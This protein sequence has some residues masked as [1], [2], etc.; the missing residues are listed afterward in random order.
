M[1]VIALI[2]VNYNGGDHLQRCLE[3]VHRQIRPPDRCLLVDNDSRVSP[4]HGDEP[5]LEGVELI[6]TGRN[7]GFAAA[8]NLAA[9]ACPEATWIALLNP[10]TVP[11][12]DW[13]QQLERVAEAHPEFTSFASQLISM[14]PPERLDGAGDGLTLAGRPYRRGFGRPTA[15]QREAR[16]VFSPC[17]AAAFFRQDRFIA[18]GGLDEAFFCYLEDVDLGFRLQLLGDRCLYTPN[19]RVRHAGS[20]LTGYRS[21]FST[22][23]G[24][25][26]MV[27][28]F[29]KN[30]PG[31]LFW[32][33]LPLHLIVSLAAMVR[34]G[35]RGQLQVFA[36]AKLHAWRGLPRMWQERRSIQAQ[37][38]QSTWAIARIL[39]RR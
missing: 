27:W 8:N 18:A 36:K 16:E 26:N 37:R 12:S 14:E 6:R 38:R 9:A 33:C 25:R 39:L 24:H 28:L 31:W 23:F 7:L 22:Y 4:V 10:D 30:M 29:V 15:S 11:A 32:A 19:A 3:A 17:G 13:L 35:R 2:I 34:C 5:W 1:T 21:D 20:A